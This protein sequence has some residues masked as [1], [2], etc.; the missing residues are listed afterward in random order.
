MVPV[1]SGTAA[2]VTGTLASAGPAESPAS[3]AQDNAHLM[4]ENN[5]PSIVLVD[6]AANHAAGENLVRG[7][8]ILQKIFVSFQRKAPRD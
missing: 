2:G 3:T 1:I 5:R 6:D 8:R 4:R 7:K